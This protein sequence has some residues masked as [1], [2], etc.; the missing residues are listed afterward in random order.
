MRVL[1]LV[2]CICGLNVGCQA[3]SL[4]ESYCD[5][6]DH[7]ND[8]YPTP[9]DDCYHVELDLQRIGRRDWCQSPWTGMCRRA[10]RSHPPYPQDVLER[11]KHVI[12][13]L[14]SASVG[15]AATSLDGGLEGE[16]M[17]AEGY[18]PPV[19]APAAEPL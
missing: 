16:Q 10:C 14:P 12:P 2:G 8:R 13:G 17:P 6:I 1:L 19:P 3:F 11:P 15:D 4:T 7:V 5:L 18:V 9:V